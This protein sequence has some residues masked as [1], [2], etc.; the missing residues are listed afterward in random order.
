M[1]RL[2]ADMV[3]VAEE[4]RG[5]WRDV[6]IVPGEH[7]D[8]D[9]TRCPLMGGD[10]CLGRRCAFA[11]REGAGN[12]YGQA[13]GANDP[14]EVEYREAHGVDDGAVLCYSKTRWTCRATEWARPT[15]DAEYV[16]K[17]RPYDER[18]AGYHRPR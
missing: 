2:L 8:D 5:G 1:G 7:T 13:D 4:E 18:T 11:V 17:W 9:A 12:Y 3:R 16:T 14:D 6:E 10:R 15:V